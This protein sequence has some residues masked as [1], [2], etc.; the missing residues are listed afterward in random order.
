VTIVEAELWKIGQ[1]KAG[2]S[3]ASARYLSASLGVEARCGCVPDTLSGKLPV[4]RPQARA[5]INTKSP[6]RFERRAC[7]GLP[8]RRRQVPAGGIRPN[9]LDLN[10][11]FAS[12]H[13]NSNYVR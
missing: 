11:R 1:L 4:R 6:L 13:W 8:G 2:D 12:M 7:G 5:K 3:C 10:L 9:V